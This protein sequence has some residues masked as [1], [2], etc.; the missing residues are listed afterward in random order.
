MPKKLKNFHFSSF[1]NHCK[2]NHDEFEEFSSQGDLK[3][4]H[5]KKEFTME[6]LIFELKVDLNF[7]KIKESY[8]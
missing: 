4:C 7:K 2:Q 5:Q 8:R 3:I 1:D 6:Q